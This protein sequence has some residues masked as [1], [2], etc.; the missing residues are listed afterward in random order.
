MSTLRLSLPL[1][2]GR[3]APVAGRL[4]RLLLIVATV[5][6]TSLANADDFAKAKQL[7]DAREYRAAARLLLPLAKKG[8]PRAQHLLGFSY[9]RGD[10]YGYDYKKAQFWLERAVAQD[11]TPA[12]GPLGQLLLRKNDG[13]SERGFRLIRTGVAR[14]D[15]Y[16]Q[17]A[18]GWIHLYGQFGVPRNLQESRRLFLMAAEQKYKYAFFHFAIWNA[19][20]QGKQPDYVEVL[21]WV[22]VDRQIGTGGVRIFFRKKAMKH[23]TKAQVA[24]AKRRAAA[25][26]K[27]HGE[28]P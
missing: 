4:L 14:G 20:D 26:L 5:F 24:E 18:L 2:C 21:K 25:W 7:R 6:C 11:Y 3:D 12:F 28:T 13:R 17:S 16:A 8:D 22:I 27:A 23:L 9:Y 15:A 1:T 19:H 10:G